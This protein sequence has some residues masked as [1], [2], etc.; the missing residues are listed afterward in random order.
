VALRFPRMLRWRK[1]KPVQEANTLE[2][3]HA[4]LEVY[5]NG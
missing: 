4:L 5:Q 2:D 3:L 1:D